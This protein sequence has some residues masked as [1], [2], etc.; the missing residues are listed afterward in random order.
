MTHKQ[1]FGAVV[2][3]IFFM[4]ASSVVYWLYTSSDEARWQIAPTVPP[5]Q[6]TTKS[7]DVFVPAPEK[8]DDITARI[9]QQSDGDMAALD[10]EMDGAVEEIDAD[11][12]SINNLGTSYDENTF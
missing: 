10:A 5:G 2:G 8:I 3:A 6:S 1:L 9:M 7:Q 4:L 11:S 12:E